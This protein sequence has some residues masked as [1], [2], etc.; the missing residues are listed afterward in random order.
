MKRVAVLA[1]SPAA[2]ALLLAA[3]ALAAWSLSGSG[4]GSA[5]AD[6]LQ[7]A[8][9][10]AAGS[11][12]SSSLWLSWDYPS[13][14]LPP[15]GWEILRGATDISSTCTYATGALACVDSGLSPSTQYSYSIKPKLGDWRGTGTQAQGTTL[16]APVAVPVVQVEAPATG[17]TT[18]TLTPVIS[19]T[20]SATASVSVSISGDAV[21]R[22]TLTVTP[23]GTSA[24]YHWQVQ[25]PSTTPLL[26][27]TTYTAA[28]SSTNVAG[29]G[30]ASS[31][32]TAGAAPVV[33]STPPTVTGIVRSSATP[34]NASSLSW[35]VTFSEAVSEVD[36][37]DFSLANSGL[38]SPSITGVTGSG[39]SYTVTAGTGTGSGTLGLNLVDNDSV[40]DGSGNRLGGFGAGNGNLTGEVYSVDKAVPTAGDIQAINGSGTRGRIDSG[41]KITYSFSEPV[42]PQS[43]LSSW[44]GSS[45]R[46]VTVTFSDNGAGAT[47]RISSITA[48]GVTV[49]LG[50]VNFGSSGNAGYLSGTGT[51]TADMTM[52]G[53]TVT[54][55]LNGGPTTATTASGSTTLVWLP[56][57]A[58]KDSAGNTMAVTA[59]QE[60]GAIDLDF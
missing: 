44:D 12:T 55:S 53:S 37:S 15:T 5:K 28:A 54:L 56:S 45:S 18:T 6:S 50:T 60:S 39:N 32:F 20:S 51:A 49:N 47:E 36:A 29:T 16:A 38:S 27:G 10:G 33:D 35:T 2:L 42:T 17:T 14:G 34:S 59:A 25:V 7:P 8:T 22:A 19:G 43:V 30:R 23:T 41:D 1:S 21:Q 31:R 11:A 57:S 24:P 13:N 26:A 46:S 58:V 52:S 4:T 3:P 9:G 40:Q 48:S